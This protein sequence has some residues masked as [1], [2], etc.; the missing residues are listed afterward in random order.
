ME[1]AYHRDIFPAAICG[2][3]FRRLAYSSFFNRKTK[4]QELSCF[5]VPLQSP[6]SVPSSTYE[7]L[8]FQRGEVTYL[9]VYLGKGSVASGMARVSSLLIFS[10]PGCLVPILGRNNQ[11]GH[12]PQR[13]YPGASCLLNSIHPQGAFSKPPVL[14]AIVFTGSKPAD[15]HLNC[16][17]DNAWHFRESTVQLSL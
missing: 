12:F 1:V 10:I 11:K 3:V 16:A 9:R 7:E 2:I 8:E 6:T 17:W 13:L 4:T 14:P 5:K 15:R